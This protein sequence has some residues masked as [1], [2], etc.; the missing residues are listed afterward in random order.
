MTSLRAEPELG[1][2]EP[3]NLGAARFGE[4]G[5]RIARLRGEKSWGRTVLAR[6]LGVSR[7]RL[8]KWERGD[9]APPLENLV[10]LGALL[11]V[12]LDELVTG[13]PWAGDAPRAGERAGAV[14]GCEEGMERVESC[15]MEI[16]PNREADLLHLLDCLRCRESAREWLEGRAAGEGL[17]VDPDG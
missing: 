11:G 6:K 16:S 8:S 15:L 14:S 2:A 5:A 9:N 13:K 1:A 12:T 7:D 3:A 10:L 4:L 17:G